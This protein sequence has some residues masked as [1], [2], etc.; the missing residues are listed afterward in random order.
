VPSN[1][2][3]AL[4][5][6]NNP[7]VQFWDSTTHGYAILDITPQQLTCTFKSVSTIRLPIARLDTLRTFTVPS[8]NVV[9]SQ[10]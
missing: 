3:E 5:L 2:L 7:H 9:L 1:L 6:R 4:V 8:G 10:S